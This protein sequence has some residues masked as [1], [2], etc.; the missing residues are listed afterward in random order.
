M[1]GITERARQ[2][3]KRILVSKVDHPAARLRLTDGNKG[4][5]GL[6]V[7][8]EL[9]GDEVVEHEGYNL[10]TIEKQLAAKLE[11]VILDV[12]DT[13]EGLQLIIHN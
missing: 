6:S 4:D 2:E 13:P 3:L 11:G 5:L 1:I 12:E 7:D 10:L 9:P 8:V